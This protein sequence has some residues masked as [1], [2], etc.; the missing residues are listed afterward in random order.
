MRVDI[1]S[2]WTPGPAIVHDPDAG[3]YAERNPALQGHTAA[4]Q[5][6]LLLTVPPKVAERIKAVQTIRGENWREHYP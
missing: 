1:G 6:A 2:R 4:M 3:I 5:R